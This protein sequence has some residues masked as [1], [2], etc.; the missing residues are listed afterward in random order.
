MEMITASDKNYTP[1]A[2]WTIPGGD[3]YEL[4]DGRLVERNIS[5]W[6]SYVAGVIFQFLNSFAREHRLGWVFPEGT[7]FQCF[8]ADPGKVRR[9]DVAFIRLQRLSP[10][11]AITEGHGHVSPDLAVE[12][13][14]PNDA[15]CEIHEKVRD[16]L[17]AG[18][19]VVWVVNAEQR[20]VEIHRANGP[21]TIVRESDE[22]VGETVIPGF[23]CRV[24]EFTQSPP[25][26]Q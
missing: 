21:G 10:A 13:V 24:R 9:P 25:G 12:V 3:A 16:Y 6:S 14:S 15:T 8:P 17:D 5:I 20:T 23:R 18:V 11:Q 26:A 4:V 22:I 2:L 1:E 7:S 19:P